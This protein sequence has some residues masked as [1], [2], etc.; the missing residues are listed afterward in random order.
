MGGTGFR[1]EASMRSLTVAFLLFLPAFPSCFSFLLRCWGSDLPAPGRA[2]PHRVHPRV[3]QAQQARLRLIRRRAARL[4][5]LLRMR[6]RL[7]HRPTLRHLRCRPRPTVPRRPA[8]HGL[9][10]QVPDRY[11]TRE[12]LQRSDSLSRLWRERN[13]IHTNRTRNRSRLTPRLPASTSLV[14]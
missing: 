11:V 14:P 8:T 3:R 2:Q 5:Q 1:S 13:E 12:C 10:R 6:R 4:A 7:P 9:R